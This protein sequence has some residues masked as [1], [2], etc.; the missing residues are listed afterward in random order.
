MRRSSRA[1]RRWATYTAASGHCA[2]RSS[3][4]MRTMARGSAVRTASRTGRAKSCASMISVSWKWRRSEESAGGSQLDLEEHSAPARRIRAGDA[5]R[6]SGGAAALQQPGS[7][8]VFDFRRQMTD[9][10]A[11]LGMYP[12]AGLIIGGQARQE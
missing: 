6:A 11:V 10:V 8:P 12:A 3:R 1:R 5:E 9:D 2:N 7:E 4:S